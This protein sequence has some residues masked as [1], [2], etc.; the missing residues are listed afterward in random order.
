MFTT[1]LEMT[2]IYIQKPAFHSF[3][4]PEGTCTVSKLQC[5]PLPAFPVQSR[6]GSDLLAPREL[7]LRSF[8]TPARQPCQAT[9]TNQSQGQVKSIILLYKGYI[10]HIVKNYLMTHYSLVKMGKQAEA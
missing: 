7:Q 9:G 6:P 8:A 3:R 4:T 5:F 1:T 2:V 10:D